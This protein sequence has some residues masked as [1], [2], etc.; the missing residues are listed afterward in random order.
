MCVIQRSV[1]GITPFEDKSLRDWRQER[2]RKP[3][4]STPARR[5]ANTRQ[6]RQALPLQ[7]EFTAPHVTGFQ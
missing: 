6:S 5:Q 4:G 7:R 1:L 3:L 2:R